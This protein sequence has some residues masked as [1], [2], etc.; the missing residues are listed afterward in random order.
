MH[1][2]SK[3]SLSF[4]FPHQNHV[5]I[6][7]LL[8]TCI[9]PTSSRPPFCHQ[10][11]IWWT[12]QI[13]QHLYLTSTVDMGKCLA[14]RTGVFIPAGIAPVPTGWIPELVWKEQRREC[15]PAP[16]G[17]DSSVVQPVAQLIQRLLESELSH[18][19][20]QRGCRKRRA[21]WKRIPQG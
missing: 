5:F 12:V 8:H 13:L 20:F 2:S 11:N 14:S 15:P 10:N 6:A 7:V 3:C 19:E 21:W 4:M 1:R 9:V 18:V 17:I 16:K